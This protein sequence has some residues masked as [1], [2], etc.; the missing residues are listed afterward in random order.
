MVTEYLKQSL[1]L[2]EAGL[3][4]EALSPLHVGLGLFPNSP[5]LWFEKYRILKKL[6]SPEAYKALIECRRVDPKFLP[7]LQAYYEELLRQNRVRE[8]Y[9]VLQ[10][11]LERDEQNPRWWAHKAFW[12]MHFG[13]HETAEE[14]IQRASELPHH[15]PEVLYYRA[16]FLARLGRRE[17]AAQLLHKCLQQAPE[18]LAEA[19]EEPLLRDLLPK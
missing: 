18:L 13:D 3:L 6:N 16:L 10:E 5:E 7:A 9:Q 2:S 14:A 12:A 11:L 19:S 15:G 8:A 4:R 17:E 1:H